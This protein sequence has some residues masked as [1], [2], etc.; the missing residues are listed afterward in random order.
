M[1]EDSGSPPVTASPAM[2]RASGPEML[3]GCGSKDKEE[4][5]FRLR[6]RC[7]F[8]GLGSLMNRLPFL[9]LSTRWSQRRSM[10]PPNLLNKIYYV[11]VGFKAS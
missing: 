2:S 9:R 10:S 8:R 5:R 4:I 1:D 11:M 6:R 7:F 3:G